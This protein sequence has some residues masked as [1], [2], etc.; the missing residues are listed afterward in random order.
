MTRRKAKDCAYRSSGRAVG[1]RYALLGTVLLGLGLPAAAFAQVPAA[2]SSPATVSLSIASQALDT[3]LTAFA[4]QAG[5]KL[6]FASQDV[7]GLRTQGL[8]GRFAPGDALGRLLA[9]TGLG[10][11]FTDARTVTLVK[12]PT[13]TAN[14][15]MALPPVQVQGQASAADAQDPRGPGVGY[16]ATRSETGTKSDTPL[17]EIPQAISTVTRQQMDD[18]NAQSVR[19]ALRY[20]SGVVPERNGLNGDAYEQL[21]GRGFVMEEYL[22]GLRLPNNAYNILAVDPYDLARVEVLHGPASVLY[23]QANPG[24]TVNLVSKLPTDTPQHEVFLQ[25]G[26]PGQVSGGFDLSGPV[27]PD[28]QL[29]YRL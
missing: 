25:G 9:G 17:I 8:S 11:R 6:L 21:Y 28:G 15:A 24:G 2:I 22:D 18:Q 14:G 3:A 13:G 16:V 23:G 19:D 29:L 5:L 7:S 20:T 12:A 10:Y 1:L 4:D 26:S 27:D